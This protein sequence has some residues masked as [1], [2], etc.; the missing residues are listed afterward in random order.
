MPAAEFTPDILLDWY[1]AS[2]QRMTK[3]VLG[4]NFA[5]PTPFNITHGED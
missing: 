4:L 2:F 5:V 1:D 3:T